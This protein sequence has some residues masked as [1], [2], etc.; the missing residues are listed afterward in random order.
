M[1]VGEGERRIEL[2]GKQV[3]ERKCGKEK[4]SDNTEKSGS[5]WRKMQER[6]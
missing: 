6:K 5:K 1:K 2:E 4:K 3:K